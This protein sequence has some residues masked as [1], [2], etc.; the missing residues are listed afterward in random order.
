MSGT[1][2]RKRLKW[3]RWLLLA[4]VVLYFAPVIPSGIEFIACNPEPPDG[5]G[6]CYGGSTDIELTSVSALVGNLFLIQVRTI[7][8]D[9]PWTGLNAEEDADR[10]RV[11]LALTHTGFFYTGRRQQQIDREEAW[12]WTERGEYARASRQFERIAR[13]PVDDMSFEYR[14]GS[15]WWQA[16]RTASLAGDNDR[17]RA[18]AEDRLAILSE[19]DDRERRG[20]YR[21]MAYLARQSGHFEEALDLLDRAVA[22]EEFYEDNAMT[23]FNRAYVFAERFQRTASPADAERAL[24]LFAEGERL[25]GLYGENAG[26]LLRVWSEPMMMTNRAEF[27]SDLGRC[28]ESASVLD[29][30]ID[31]LPVDVSDED[32]CLN[33][34]VSL[35]EINLADARCRLLSMRG[36]PE[37]DAVCEQHRAM[38]GRQLCYRWMERMINPFEPTE[39]LACFASDDAPDQGGAA[40]QADRG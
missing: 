12:L 39:P 17:A 34:G 27:L 37:A 32:R 19:D 11:W 29:A 20:L 4:L 1:E 7:R 2:K 15:D 21:Y 25:Y 33:D 24:D 36:A 18:L 30:A 16:I 13:S 26:H 35:D 40:D 3:G 38:L 14:S 6:E 9:E 31:R 23:T 22:P 8:N 5:D 10:A 28:Q